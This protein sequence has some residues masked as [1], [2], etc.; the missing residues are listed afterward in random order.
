[1]IFKYYL[2][3]IN[4]YDYSYRFAVYHDNHYFEYDIDLIKDFPDYIFIDN[5]YTDTSWYYYIVKSNTKIR[6]DIDQFDISIFNRNS[7]PTYVIKNRSEY[8]I[9]NQYE[10]DKYYYLLN[11]K[12]DNGKLYKKIYTFLINYYKQ[13]HLTEN[14]PI[15]KESIV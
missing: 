1:M 13:K 11:K 6:G 7:Y 2:Y 3:T 15:I 12:N 4:P 9:A 8:K 5:R 10:V 14:T